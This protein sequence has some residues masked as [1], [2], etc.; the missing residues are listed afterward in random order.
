MRAT[1]RNG[2]EVADKLGISDQA[3]AAGAAVFALFMPMPIHVRLN[4]DSGFVLDMLPGWDKLMALPGAE[5][6]ALL[7]TPEGRRRMLAPFADAERTPRWARWERY[8]IYEC[9]TPETRAYEG[10]IV[11]DIARDEGKDAWDALCDIVVADDLRTTF[12]FPDAVP[13]DADWEA[14][15]RVLRDPRIVVGAS[16]AGAHLDMIDTFAYTTHLFQD[17]VRERGL[18]TTEEVV[19]LLTAVPAGLYGLRD[20]GG[21]RAG[22]CADVVVFDE[23]SIGVGPLHTRAD[24][25]GGAKRLFADGIGIAH[26]LVNGETVVEHGEVTDARS[27]RVL[28]SGVDTSTVATAAR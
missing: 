17:V 15:A 26:V 25:P 3:Q 7:R 24:L 13:S 2:D 1:A 19:H 12:G 10:R 28:R 5:K 4:L 6:L 14:C 9:F 11:G 23:D 22:S 18:L 20:R 16:D 8:L 21:L 27:G